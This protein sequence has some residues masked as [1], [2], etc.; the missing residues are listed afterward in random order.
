[1]KVPIVVLCAS[2]ATIAVAQK[3]AEAQCL[4]SFNGTIGNGTIGSEQQV[5]SLTVRTV[6][7]TDANQGVAVDKEYFYSIDNYSIT[8]HNKTTG[9]PLQQWYG[10]PDGPIIHLDG[11]VVINGTLY[12]PHSNYPTFPETSSVEEWNVTTMEHIRTH[13]FGIYRGSLT[14]V[15]QDSTGT[16]YGTFANY[17]SQ[18]WIFPKELVSAN[19]APMS[20]SGGSFAPDGW[21]YITGH[22]ASAAYVMQIPAAGNVLIWVATVDLPDIAGQGIA[23][24]RSAQ[25]QGGNGTLYGIS[26]ES[27]QVVEMRV[28]LQGCRPNTDLPVG[29]VLGPEDFIDPS[30]D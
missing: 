19:F 21:L 2:F 10:G 13:S 23:W 6:N 17:I 25:A 27:R 12:A 29:I 7:S 20:N 26:R 4:Q 30:S 18:S 8:K 24:D 16:W 5:S 22:D 15:D 14:W 1:M 28:P 3:Q 9:R 11:G